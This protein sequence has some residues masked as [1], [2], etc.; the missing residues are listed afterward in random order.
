MGPTEQ[1]IARQCYNIGQPIPERIAN[2]PEL[3]LGS[4]L[5]LQAFFDLDSTRNHGMG[6]TRIS[7]TSIKDYAAAFE[8][9]CRQTEDLF[10]YIRKLDEANLI[11]LDE[12]I[13]K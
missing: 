7:W 6:L 9:D 5:Y 12:K 13:P 4:Q 3:M 8:L 2:A 11:R 1:H 10:Y